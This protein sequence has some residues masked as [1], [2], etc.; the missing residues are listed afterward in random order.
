MPK[1][2]TTIQFSVLPNVDLLPYINAGAQLTGT[3]SGTQPMMDF[4]YDGV[5][6]ITVKI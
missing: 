1:G 3:A 5:V 6:V 4:T 2:Q